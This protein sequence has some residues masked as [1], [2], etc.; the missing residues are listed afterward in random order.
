MDVWYDCF[1]M[2]GYSNVTRA[3]GKHGM[4]WSFGTVMDN[5]SV[6]IMDT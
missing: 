3:L 4:C 1:M 2:N 5:T 6:L